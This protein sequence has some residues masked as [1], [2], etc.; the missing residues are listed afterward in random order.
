M[1][2][3]LSLEK[4]VD[5]PIGL[6]RLRDTFD[7]LLFWQNDDDGGWATYEKRRAGKWLELLNQSDVFGDIMVDYSYVELTSSAMQGLVA[8]R[9]RF[10]DEL[11]AERLAKVE[12]ALR[13]GERFLRAA[14][15]RDGSFEGSWAV[16]FT[17]GAW[18]G[19]SGLR[20]AGVS[21]DDP[22]MQRAVTFLLGKQN[23][24]G[25][26]GESYKSSE[27]R[28]YVQ[29]PDGSQVVMTAW[30]VLALINSGR[31]EAKSAISRGAQFLLAKQLDDGDWPREG[32][33]GVFNRSC[34][35]H[36]RFYRNYFPLWALALARG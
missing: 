28:R 20:A 10:G 34:M 31:P 7:L 21:S 29:H 35:I 22:A 19:V 2:A 1:K 12:K 18:F 11:G 6:D 24:D 23:Q 27:Q 16:C 33:S 9:D 8:A 13:G 15:R 25:G 5:K 14:Q 36:Y 26:W 3:A 17:Y 30:A 32:I 4:F